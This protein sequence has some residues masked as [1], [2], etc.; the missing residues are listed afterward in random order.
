[1]KPNQNPRAGRLSISVDARRSGLEKKRE[2]AMV[3]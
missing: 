1:M 2:R 3:F